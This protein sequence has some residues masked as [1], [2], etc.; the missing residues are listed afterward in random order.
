MIGYEAE[1]LYQ[2]IIAQMEIEDDEQ[3]EG[4]ESQVANFQDFLRGRGLTAPM[5]QA[6]LGIVDVRIVY[7]PF[8]TGDQNWLHNPYH[9]QLVFI[10]T[11]YLS[12]HGLQPL[13]LLLALYRIPDC[14]DAPIRMD[15]IPAPAI[16]SRTI[17]YW[18]SPI[19]GESNTGI[20]HTIVKGSKAF[21]D[22]KGLIR[23]S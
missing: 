15:H 22:E 2:D 9:I 7:V 10:Y 3:E 14:V 6:I 16:P 17:G 11:I 18:T 23:N 4:E 1:E 13:E 5:M 21:H 19:Y 12:P 20:L 8:P